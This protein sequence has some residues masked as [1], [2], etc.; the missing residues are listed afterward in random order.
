VVIQH[1]SI[2]LSVQ[3]V[4]VTVCTK[5]FFSAFNAYYVGP[6]CRH[7]L[8]D[9]EHHIA[10]SLEEAS[11]LFQ[12]IKNTVDWSTIKLPAAPVMSH[13]QNSTLETT[14]RD[15]IYARQLQAQFNREV[16]NGSSERTRVRRERHRSPV[17]GAI[18]NLVAQV[19]NQ[20]DGHQKTCGHRCDLDS[21]RQCCECSGKMAAMKDFLLRSSICFY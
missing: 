20:P 19:V 12:A 13:D 9:D 17:Q 6:I 18:R 10:Y 21:T 7:A 4:Y 11:R 3:T 16:V 14:N 5:R 2:I 15:E 1:V 8:R